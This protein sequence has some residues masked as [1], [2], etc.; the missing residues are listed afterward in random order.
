MR[1]A[2]ALGFIDKISLWSGKVVS[3]LLFP[4]IAVLVYGVVARYAFGSPIIWGHETSMFMFGA[5]GLL[6]G[7]YCFQRGAHVRM[8]MFYNR[9]SP[10]R[11]AVVDALTAAIFFYFIVVLM[12]QGAQFAL[13]SIAKLEHSGSV[14]KPVVYP[15]KTVIPVA[16]FLVLL[17]GFAKFIRD[18]TFAI[19]G[20]PLS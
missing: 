18:L 15:F 12:W 11:K 14:W 3:Y 10:R 1:L 16:A 6:A 17:Q 9:L 19:Y 20:K 13:H 5:I 8:D 2:P 4:L 7:A